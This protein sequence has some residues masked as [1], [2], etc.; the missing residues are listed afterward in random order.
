M[1]TDKIKMHCE[2]CKQETSTMVALPKRRYKDGTVICFWQLC[3]KCAK[4]V[5]RE[6]IAKDAAKV[7]KMSKPQDS[8]SGP[9][10]KSDDMRRVQP[11]VR[12]INGGNNNEKKCKKS[13]KNCCCKE[14]K[15]A[16]AVNT[17]RP[18]VRVSSGRRKEG[19]DKLRNDD[20]LANV[21][22]KKKNIH[23]NKR[24]HI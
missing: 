14:R 12:R 19:R 16:K 17:R 8:T 20:E 3:L 22:R 1:K 18:S 23:I 15:K 7:S 5:L 21:R 24:A 10:E 11:V 6:R 13:C 4:E 9:R 2:K